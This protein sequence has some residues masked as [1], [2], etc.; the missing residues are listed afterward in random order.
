MEKFIRYRWQSWIMLIGIANAAALT[1]VLLG[2][3]FLNTYDSLM[4]YLLTWV[5]RGA[6]TLTLF[7]GIQEI[8]FTLFRTIPGAI[9]LGGWI[10]LLFVLGGAVVAWIYSM[11]KLTSMPRRASQ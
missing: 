11:F 6:A 8:I 5:Y 2:A 4:D 7:N 1:L 3:Q 10:V 9:P